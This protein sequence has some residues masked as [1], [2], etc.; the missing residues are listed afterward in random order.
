MVSIPR[1]G[2][3]GNPF[4]VVLGALVA[5][6]VEEEKRIKFAGFAEAEGPAELDPGALSRGLGL[7]NAL[8]RS[9]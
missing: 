8:D 6:I 3:Q 5:E 1:W 4:E 9:E 2:C 7:G